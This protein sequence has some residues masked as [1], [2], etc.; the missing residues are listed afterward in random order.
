MG[1]PRW[2][3][4]GVALLALAVVVLLGMQVVRPARPLVEQ[5]AF[6]QERITPNADG[7]DDATTFRYTLSRN[8]TVSLTFTSADGQEYTFRAAEPRVAGDYRVLFSGVVHGY[9]L[10]GENVEGEV[11]ARLLQDGVYTW[12]LSAVDEQGETQTVSGALTIVDAD[13]LLPDLTG[14]T[15]SPDVFSPNQDGVADRVNVHVYVIKPARLTMYLEGEDGERFYIAERNEGRLP[16]E[17]GAHVFDYDGGIDAGMEPPP[18]GD[19]VLML[20]AEDEEGQRVTRIGSLAIRNSGLPL[21]EIYAQPTG[22]TVFYDTMPYD[23]AFYTS[24]EVVGER[25]PIPEGVESMISAETVLQGDMLV[26]RLTVNNYGTVGL[27]TTGPPPGTVYHQEQR[28]SSLG[29]IDESGAW[30]VGL[31]CDTATSDYPWR[32]ALGDLDVLE[33]VEEGGETYYY[34]PP[35]EQAVV[36]GAVRL[37]DVVERRNPQQCWAGL[38]HEDVEIPDRQG[39]VDARWVE[40]VPRPEAAR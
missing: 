3:T 18:D 25:I 20:H 12:R 32:W 38:I 40:I 30:R 1:I 10:P 22:T 33:A 28:A 5:A 21:G 2:I 14:F 19:Y 16:G 29:W 8:A 24:A 26:F 9:T 37:T 39:R 31:D 17:E 35:G 13:P 15:I 34:L 36:W 23:P 6:D 27:R 7:Q 4:A 11:E